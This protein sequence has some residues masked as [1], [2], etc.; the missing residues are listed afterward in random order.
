MNIRFNGELTEV[1]DAL[2]LAQLLAQ[3]PGLPDNYAVALNETFVPRAAYAGTVVA[4]GDE[5]ELVVPMQGG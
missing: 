1:Q 2:T 3:M 4:A 5:V